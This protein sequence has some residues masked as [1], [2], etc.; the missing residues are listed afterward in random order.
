M[1]QTR[2]NR[3]KYKPTDPLLVTQ[4][5]GGY[6]GVSPGTMCNWRSKGV[7]PKY[8]KVGGLVKYQLS[9]LDKFI[10]DAERGKR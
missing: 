10:E 8:L 6:I 3:R 9:G 5:A 7:G 2:K 1:P 4:D